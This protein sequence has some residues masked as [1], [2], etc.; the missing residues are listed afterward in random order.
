MDS[1]EYFSQLF[2]RESESICLSDSAYKR[3]VLS[4]CL[5]EIQASFTAADLESYT[6][7]LER[8]LVPTV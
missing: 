4:T 5:G 1:F 8:N 3:M 7:R 6:Y 2:F